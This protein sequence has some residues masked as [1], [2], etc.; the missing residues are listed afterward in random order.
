M[1][2]TKHTRP[3]VK[4]P[5]F[6]KIVDEKLTR[7]SLS[8]HQ[9]A[10]RLG[11]TAEMVRRYREG[12]TMPRDKSMEKLAI[13]IG[14]SPSEL[15]YGVKGKGD[16]MPLVKLSPDEETLL[17]DYRA[18]PRDLQKMARARIVELLEAFTPA[19]K[20]NPYGKGTQ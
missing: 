18:L 15:R 9:A 11:V 16:K 6:G 20:K 13:L 19:S 5:A 14:V 10:K 1:V 7:A 12:W 4:Y 17:E 3:V 8:N 2:D